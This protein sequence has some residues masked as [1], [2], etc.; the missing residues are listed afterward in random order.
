MLQIKTV[1]TDNDTSAAESCNAAEQVFTLDD[2]QFLIPGLIDAHIHPVQ[3]PNLGMGYDKHL[4]DWLETYT[5][6]LEKRFSDVN[7]ASQVFE[8][9]VVRTNVPRRKPRRSVISDNMN[10]RET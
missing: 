2:G 6:P 10:V 9:V 3:F 1:S 5:F 4:L 8:A 7:F